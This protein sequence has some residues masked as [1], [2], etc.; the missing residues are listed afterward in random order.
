MKKQK[1]NELRETAYLKDG[2]KTLLDSIR[3]AFEDLFDSLVALPENAT[4]DAKLELISRC[5]SQINQFED[6]IETVE[7]ESILEAIYAI[8]AVVGLD[9]STEFA[10]AFRGDW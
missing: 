2:H 3:P 7:R 6:D 1:L 8:G 9:S 10:E 4:E 5:F